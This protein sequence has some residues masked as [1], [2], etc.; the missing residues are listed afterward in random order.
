[1][2]FW[3]VE[4]KPG[5]PFKLRYED[6]NGRLYLAQATLGIGTSTKKCILQCKVGDG[7]PIFLCTLLPDKIETCPLNLEFEENDV[8]K[9]AVIGST[10]IHLSGV[11]R[12]AQEEGDED[13]Y[14]SDMYG[15]D[16]YG[17]D[18]EESSYSDSEEDPFGASE[19]DMF[20]SPARPSGVVIE[21][22][23]DDG[24]AATGNVKTKLTKGE[25]D[26]SL[27][28]VAKGSATSPVLQSEDEDGFPVPSSN[29]SE[30]GTQKAEGNTDAIKPESASEK[31]KKKKKQTDLGKQ[32]GPGEKSLKRK[33]DAVVNDEGGKSDSIRVNDSS[34][35]TEALPGESMKQ[36]NKKKKKDRG[37][38]E[39]H[40]AFDEDKSD[41]KQAEAVRDP[42]SNVNNDSG[43]AIGSASDEQKKGKK[44]KK[45]KSQDSQGAVGDKNTITVVSDN[46]VSIPEEGG[47]TPK[48]KRSRIREYSNGLIIEELEMGKPDGKRASPG[49]KL[50]VKY[51]GKLQ[52]NGQIFDSNINK[53]PFPFRLG[54]GAVIKG[55][56][57]G[58]EGMRVGDKRRLTIP[59]QMGYGAKGAPPKIPPNSWLVFD[60]EL[61]DVS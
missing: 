36:K 46:N 58:V 4:V 18:S 60:V 22:I 31:E 41:A 37:A 20:P 28:I 49:K 14:D 30:T 21:E 9:F 48:G 5:K 39:E 26:Q 40:V 57:V 52:K 59:P 61:I 13:D 51:I 15:E 27:Q 24:S 35:P 55:W 17:T 33:A 53:A 23:V 34:L 3:G 42:D 19:D 32:D 2:A 16:I 7:K 6:V 50:K 25:R 12:G 8:V 11:V 47:K 1:M 44:K 29:R 56:D 45:G 54:V 10:S 43:A 38:V